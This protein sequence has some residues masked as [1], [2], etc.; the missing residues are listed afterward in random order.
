MTTGPTR[1]LIER[2]LQLIASQ[3][4]GVQAIYGFGSFF[5]SNVFSDIDIVL[6][7]TSDCEDTLGVF[8]AFLE[9]VSL[10]GQY[11]NTRFDVTPLTTTE[12]MRKP[13]RESDSLVPIFTRRAT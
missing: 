1:S 9:R 4:V 6:V 8:E 5:R 7:F 3:Q 10:L 13:L 2:E 12:F 11:V